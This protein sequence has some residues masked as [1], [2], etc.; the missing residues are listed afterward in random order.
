[1]AQ[2][3]PLPK[4]RL[5]AWATLRVM[6]LAMILPSAPHASR[7]ATLV[8]GSAA[9]RMAAIAATVAL[10]FPLYRQ[11]E[12]VRRSALA[13]M[14]SIVAG[15]LTAMFSAVAIAWALGATA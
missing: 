2:A 10:A 15:S 5:M 14:A 12:Q 8:N 6:A 7:I 9:V 1:M 11:F 13:L 4:R 3:A